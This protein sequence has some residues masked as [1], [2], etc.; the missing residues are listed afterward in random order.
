[1]GSQAL[2]I[3]LITH[4]YR[5]VLFQE[6]QT[7]RFFLTYVKATLMMV[8][9]GE[10]TLLWIVTVQFLFSRVCKTS[11]MFNFIQELHVW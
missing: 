2:R 7:V 4:N 6:G 9:K 1:M 3:Q 8:E 5:Q 10:Q 11:S